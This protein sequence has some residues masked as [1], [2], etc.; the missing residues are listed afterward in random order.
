MKRILASAF[1]A[2][3]FL[4]PAA[5]AFADPVTVAT[6]AGEVRLDSRPER[7]AVYDMAALDTLDALGVGAVAGATNDTFLPYLEKYEGDL[8]TLFEPDLEALNAL[9][10]DLVIAGGRSGPQIGALS[11]IAPTIDMTIGTDIVGDAKA[12]LAAYGTL[13]GREAEAEA[14]GRELDA[15]LEAA[16]SAIA[17]KGTGLVILT[18]GPKISAYG[19]GSRFGWLH[20]SLGLPQA[21]EDLDAEANHGEAVSF[22]FIR[23]T[24]PDWLLVIDR[25]AAIGAEGAGAAATLDNPL[26][27]DT[28]AWKNGQVVYL[29]AGELY[30]AGGGYTSLTHTLDLIADAFGDGA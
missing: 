26:V 1:C 19:A 8:G 6:A 29:N 24:D 23:K 20:E 3:T 13:F 9:A 30:I 27:A 15:R 22:E 21:A 2:A 28:T 4:L 7:V 25:V 11:R 18:N 5:T 17:G 16:R 12:R 14:L 10:P